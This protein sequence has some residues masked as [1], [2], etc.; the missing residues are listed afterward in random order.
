MAYFKIELL[1]S[2]NGKYLRNI[3][4]EFS[5]QVKNSVSSTSTISTE[6]NPLKA[7]Y[8]NYNSAFTYDEKFEIHQNGQKQLTFTM[9]STIYKSGRTIRNPFA[10]NIIIGSLLL[11]TDNYGNE[12]LMTV[13]NIDYTFKENN[14]TYSVTCQDSFTYQSIRQ[15]DGYTIENDPTSE[16]YIG[17]KTIDWWVVNKIVPDCHVSYSYVPLTRGLF[18]NKN[19]E[20]V[21]YD[22]KSALINVKKVIKPLYDRINFSDYFETFPYSVSKSNV[23]AALIA[24]GEQIGLILFTQEWLDSSGTLHKYFWFAPEK[25]DLNSTGIS[26]SPNSDIQ[27]FTL[28]HAGDSLTTVLNVN[29]PTVNDKVISMIPE[30]PNFFFQY[31]GND[32]V[33]KDS[34]F[35]PGFFESVCQGQS[36]YLSMAQ[37]KDSSV[38]TV[39]STTGTTITIYNLK[40]SAHTDGYESLDQVFK[41]WMTNYTNNSESNY[42]AFSFNGYLYVPIYNSQITITNDDNSSYNL[43][44]LKLPPFYD[45]ISFINNNLSA[46]DSRSQSIITVGDGKGDNALTAFDSNWNLILLNRTVTDGSDYSI[47]DNDSNPISAAEQ[48]SGN[49][50]GFI[51]IQK[52][53]TAENK[54][55][56]AFESY[57]RFYR[58]YSAEEMQFAKIADNC[59][60]LENRIINFNYWYSNGTLSKSEYNSLLDLIQNK[61]R[62]VN[63][64]LL[65]YTDMYYTALHA[66]TK[67]IADLTTKYDTLGAS[68]NSDIVT[69]Y[70]NK[71]AISDYS[72]FESNYN[73]VFTQKT[74]NSTGAIINY[75][76][77]L[78]KYV[79][80]YIDAEQRF[81]KNIYNFENYWNSINIF[82]GVNS[83]IQIGVDKITLLNTID[84]GDTETTQ[85]YLTFASSG[86]NAYATVDSSF[87]QYD[88]DPTSVVYGRPFITLYSNDELNAPMQIVS[89]N[90]AINYYQALKV[91]DETY[92]N[93]NNSAYKDDITYYEPIL[94]ITGELK[95]FGLTEDDVDATDLLDKFVIDKF[96]RLWK[97]YDYEITKASTDKT[98]VVF[99]VSYR[100]YT[101]VGM[102]PYDLN[103]GNTN[104][105]INLGLQIWT[106]NSDGHSGTTGIE[107]N[108]STISL[109]YEP[110]SSTDIYR[111][112]IALT[113]N[114]DT[115]YTILKSASGYNDDTSAEIDSYYQNEVKASSVMYYFNGDLYESPTHWLT[116]GTDGT[117][118]DYFTKI[119]KPYALLN[120]NIGSN[121]DDLINQ[122]GTDGQD[123]DTSDSNSTSIYNDNK[124]SYQ[125]LYRQYFPVTDLYIKDYQYRSSTDED[126]NIT[127]DKINAKG[128]I[129]NSDNNTYK[130]YQKIPFVTF[131]NQSSYYRLVHNS[132]FEALLWTGILSNPVQAAINAAIWWLDGQSLKTSGYTTS[133][134]FG[135]N[136]FLP[137][138]KDYIDGDDPDHAGTGPYYI[139]TANDIITLKNYW[140]DGTS[141]TV[142]DNATSYNYFN[143]IAKSYSNARTDY[144]PF[145][146]TTTSDTQAKYKTSRIRLLNATDN[147]NKNGKYY[148]VSIGNND[149]TKSPIIYSS[150]FFSEMEA[151]S[152]YRDATIN[153]P[154]LANASQLDVSNLD[155]S[156]GVKSKTLS[157]AWNELYNQTLGKDSSNA[158]LLFITNE[159]NS[160]QKKYFIIFEL[161]D[162]AQND[163]DYASDSTTYSNYITYEWGENPVNTAN[164]YIPS[165]SHDLYYTSNGQQVSIYD[166]ADATR[167]YYTIQQV[168]GNIQR[169]TDAETFDMNAHYYIKSNNFFTRVYTIQQIMNA[170]SAHYINNTTISIV[171]Y[172]PDTVNFTEDVIDHTITTIQTVKLNLTVT[173]A[174]IK[175]VLISAGVG[176]S[177]VVDGGDNRA[178]IQSL[179]QSGSNL[180]VTFVF[181]RNYGYQKP[182]EDNTENTTTLVLEGTTSPI[183]TVNNS[184]NWQ[185]FNRINVETASDVISEDFITTIAE[186]QSTDL[187][188]TRSIE[189]NGNTY[190]YTI[191]WQNVKGVKGITNGTFWYLYNSINVTTD[192][193][194]DTGSLTDAQKETNNN[195]VKVNTLLQQY[196]ATIESKLTEYWEQAY[197]ASNY[198]EYFIPPYWNV[199]ATQ[200]A[201]FFSNNIYSVNY[202]TI[203]NSDGSKTTS[204]SSVVLSTSLL[205]DVRKVS[206]N[207]ISE[208]PSY[209]IS[210]GSP[211]IAEETESQKISTAAVNYKTAE[212]AFSNNPAMKAAF[213]EINEDMSAWSCE[214]NGTTT[215]YKSIGGGTTWRQLITNLLKG[216]KS[217]D[218]FDGEYIMICH[219]LRQNYRN[220]D[221]SQYDYY[222]KQHNSIWSEIYSTYPN[223][224]LESSYTNDTSTTSEDLYK[225][226][227]YYFKDLAEPE[228]NYNITVIDN[229]SLRGYTGQELNI[230]DS[231]SLAANELYPDYDQ[232]KDSLSQL[233]FITDIS[234]TPRK[235]NDIQFT[236]NTIKYQDHLIRRLAKLIR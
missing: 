189:I 205:P 136:T 46:N 207:G 159:S 62:I 169:V 217:F 162:Q 52:N 196:A 78:S 227:S 38:Y 85:H 146:L 156:K 2:N 35:F 190:N 71:G 226:A 180:Y 173:D 129:D 209:K 48:N 39:D 81:L 40:D 29:G 199:S 143:L 67:I 236:V 16:D 43:K 96:K 74:N 107:I 68:F 79:N 130:T 185:T 201:N 184:D 24:L 32:A 216:S 166:F 112:Y 33:W 89:K 45:K 151:N 97:S 83:D 26:Y 64:R 144:K 69:P 37:P 25:N 134:L 128:E 191:T 57:L 187:L 122:W 59:P 231:I 221:L 178:K 17:A 23:D 140:P 15:N 65:M 121:R 188:P 109:G 123:P 63:G 142:K 95:N 165:I 223:I 34:S 149:L 150:T 202:N 206:I 183:I 106:L 86:D 117:M 120:S 8:N 211:A 102:V 10:Y 4:T 115:L 105:S 234:Y 54:I 36:Y 93:T 3:I 164:Y 124:D 119:M 27:S 84:Y 148:V 168:D 22:N 49:Y 77:T 160:S 53:I 100:Q 181:D 126:G 70:M 14:M 194:T 228:H 28:T 145:D 50:Y 55:I 133:S 203:T 58:D 193:I 163:F 141:N 219:D 175:Q 232:I 101:P 167:G 176:S 153:Y 13:K 51:R 179:V 91:A 222:L 135:E 197:A 210:F 31:I 11:Y 235:D 170:K 41:D 155:W 72:D 82:A 215:Y 174:T 198:C 108:D 229:S 161:I 224:V 114:K 172:S 137:Y 158:K 60:W 131:D 138:Y 132:N 12:Y 18:M 127:Y 233:L 76:D 66:K 103:T 113:T 104:G 192:N 225:L 147:V 195:K 98:A 42:L 90:N 111:N 99:T 87:N 154:L 94:K 9:D 47:I 44:V 214:E 88:S 110:V 20:L 218:E 6:T 157:T 92:N 152:I 5:N 220:Q 213:A 1:T 56:K 75:S 200:N 212:D 204:V 186:K 61:L 7:A 118:N 125:Q 182:N 177:W 21:S 230:G 73:T 171:N 80:N 139:S 116:M 30:I 19:N 208:L